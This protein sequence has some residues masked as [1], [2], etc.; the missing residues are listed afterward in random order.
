MKPDV[1]TSAGCLEE[2]VRLEEWSRADPVGSHSRIYFARE[3]E[4]FFAEA[5]KLESLGK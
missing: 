5:I 1:N 2:A 3:A 4:W